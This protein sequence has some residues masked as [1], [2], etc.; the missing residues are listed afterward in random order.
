MSQTN[1]PGSLRQRVTD[2][3]LHRCAYCQTAERVIGAPLE[4]DHIVPESQGGLTTE[5]NLGLACSPCNNHKADHTTALDL[6]T[7]EIVPLFNPRQQRWLDHF[8]WTK[9]SE[10]MVGLTAT[11][12]ATVVASLRPAKSGPDSA[13]YDMSLRRVAARSNDCRCRGACCPR[14]G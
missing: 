4:M 12:R 1:I 14:H 8:A 10:L 2:Y 6:V 11:G 5:E 3:F 7:G 9:D 13:A